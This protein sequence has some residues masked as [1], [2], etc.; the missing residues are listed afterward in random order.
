MLLLTLWQRPSR[1]SEG[2]R[3]H[4]PAVLRVLV[5]GPEDLSGEIDYRLVEG[6]VKAQTGLPVQVGQVRNN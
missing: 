3:L 2:T 6:V 1:K 4:S 5:I